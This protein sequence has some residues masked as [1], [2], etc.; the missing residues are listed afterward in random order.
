MGGLQVGVGVGWGLEFGGWGGICLTRV[1][2]LMGV[3]EEMGWG[4]VG[5][6]AV[7]IG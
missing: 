7:Q 1:G 2:G 4:G 6:E 3:D 5:S